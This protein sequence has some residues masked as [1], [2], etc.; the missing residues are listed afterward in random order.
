MAA[1]ASKDKWIDFL[2]EKKYEDL[3]PYLRDKTTTR[4]KYLKQHSGCWDLQLFCMIMYY[5]YTLQYNRFIQYMKKINSENDKLQIS[6]I[7]TSIY[8]SIQNPTNYLYKYIIEKQFTD[9]AFVYDI[10]NILTLDKFQGYQMYPMIIY[11]KPQGYPKYVIFHYFTIIKSDQTYYILSSWGSD[12]ICVLPSIAHI[13]KEEFS[14]LSDLLSRFNTIEIEEHEECM[15]LVKNIF[16]AEAVPMYSNRNSEAKGVKVPPQQGIELEQ[17][18][19]STKQ[20]YHIAVINGYNDIIDRMVYNGM[21]ISN[22]NNSGGSRRNKNKR[23][24]SHKSNKKTNNCNRIWNPTRNY[25]RKSR[26]N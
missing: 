2:K 25:N 23:N 3:F 14:R 13:K 1:E 19:F 10:S 12:T 11:T 16:L 18:T 6:K 8:K 24:K 5:M 17:K 9:S 22:K 4:N 21:A 7:I 15:E 20:T 26:K